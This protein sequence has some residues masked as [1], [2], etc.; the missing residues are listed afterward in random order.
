MVSSIIYET[1]FWLIIN[2]ILAAMII[3]LVYKQYAS[4]KKQNA[5]R[6]VE[7]GSRYDLEDVIDRFKS[8]VSQSK[9]G[10]AIVTSY[11]ELF[12]K[13]AGDQTP[14]H[15]T[16]SEMLDS[17][18]KLSPD[19]LEHLRIMYKIYEKVRFGG[20]QPSQQEFDT[21]LKSMQAVNAH[22]KVWGSVVKTG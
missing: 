21:F 2:I 22:M 13:V 16:F 12:I 8:L 4:T 20:H 5:V 10:E 9:G 15:L 7:S 17:S 1:E 3:G 14:S 19:V 6:E 11:R 18:I